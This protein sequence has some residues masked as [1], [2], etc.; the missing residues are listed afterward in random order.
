MFSVDPTPNEPHQI[1]PISYPIGETLDPS[2]DYL[3]NAF[4]SG[5]ENLLLTG[6]P[7]LY[8]DALLDND[9]QYLLDLQLDYL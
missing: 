3:L 7:W 5:Y 9:T 6:T 1:L 2:R 4:I 8:M